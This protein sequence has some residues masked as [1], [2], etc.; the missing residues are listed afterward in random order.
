MPRVLHEC[1]PPPS[2][3]AESGGV[4]VCIFGGGGWLEA[5]TGKRQGS[6]YGWAKIGR[7]S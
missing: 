7:S 1:L 3:D 4:G 6:I 2:K 5:E